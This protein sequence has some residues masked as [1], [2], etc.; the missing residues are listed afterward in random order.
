M[1]IIERQAVVK[2]TDMSKEM[3]EDAVDFS[4]QALEKFAVD[5]NTEIA[6]FIKKEFDR[7]HSPTWHCIVG[8]NYGSFVTHQLSHF[9]S[10]YLD[11][12]CVL[13]WKST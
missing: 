12:I 10:F 13:L 4:A 8:T 11:D 5:K 3:L 9:I 7:K 2:C 6:G 1:E